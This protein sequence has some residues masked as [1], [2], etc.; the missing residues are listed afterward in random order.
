V[1]KIIQRVLQDPAV[2]VRWASEKPGMQGGEEVPALEK[3]VAIRLWLFA[4]LLAVMIVKGL[5]KLHVHKSIANRLLEPWMWHTIVV[6]STEWDNY[7]KQR[8]SPLAQPEIHAAADAMYA[9]Y[10]ASTPKLVNYG[11]WHLPFADPDRTLEEQKRQSAACCARVSTLNHD[12][13]KSVEAD[14]KLFTSLS[15][16][17]PMHASPFEHQATPVSSAESMPWGNFDGWRQW[18]HELEFQ[19]KQRNLQGVS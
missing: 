16:A 11:E 13:V 4:R 7:W 12:G 17:D 3:F 5:I 8:C 10:N 2:P 18:R 15:T 14:E 1:R 19:R 9:A 6:T